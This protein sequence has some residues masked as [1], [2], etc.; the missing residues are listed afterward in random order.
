VAAAV[1]AVSI[2]VPDGLL[3]L[4]RDFTVAVVKTEP[5]DLD[6]FAADYFRELAAAMEA[7]A[8]ASP[9]CVQ[10]PSYLE[11][12][13]TLYGYAGPATGEHHDAEEEVHGSYLSA[14]ASQRSHVA[15]DTSAKLDDEQA[16]AKCPDE[17]ANCWEKWMKE[18]EDAE[19]AMEGAS[20]VPSA[21]GSAV[22]V[23]GSRPPSRVPSAADGATKVPGAT[24]SGLHV[25]GATGTASGVPSAAGSASNVLT[26]GGPKSATSSATKVAAARSTADDAAQ[27]AKPGASDHN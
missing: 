10:T 20:R 8:V 2:P 13:E 6:K 17:A 24:G 1:M 22:N 7:G 14:V 16:P 4:L 18:A 21:T 9:D 12:D 23:S 19:E 11:F 27:S 3:D 5:D 25:P 26:P 15:S